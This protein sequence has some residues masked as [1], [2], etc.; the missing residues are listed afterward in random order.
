MAQSVPS[1]ASLAKQDSDIAN[2]AVKQARAALLPHAQADADYT[3]NSVLK[4]RS[5]LQS[6]VALNGVREYSVLVTTA[7]ADRPP[8]P[9]IWQAT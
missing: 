2:L 7:H 9:E 1:A 8:K 6:F 4:G 3:Y 5:P